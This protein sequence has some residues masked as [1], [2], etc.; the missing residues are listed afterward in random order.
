MYSVQASSTVRTPYGPVCSQQLIVHG[1]RTEDGGV[2]EIRII[3]CMPSRRTHALKLRHDNP[4]GSK[5]LCPARQTTVGLMHGH[6][7]ICFFAS[8]GLEPLPSSR[9]FCRHLRAASTPSLGS[10]T[11]VPYSVFVLYWGT[12]GLG[13]W[14]TERLDLLKWHSN[15]GNHRR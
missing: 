5:R 9:A 7:G 10:G 1:R 15:N 8:F 2:A 4:F 14:G 11:S 3:A 6:Q 12:G 13:N